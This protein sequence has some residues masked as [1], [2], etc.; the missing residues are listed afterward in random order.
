MFYPFFYLPYATQR[1]AMDIKNNAVVGIHYTLKNSN[2][3]VLDSSEDRDPLYFLHG[4]GNIIPGL[5]S[6]LTGKSAG[7]AMEVTVEPE[8]GYGLRRDDLIQKSPR[9]AFE[10][11]DSLEVGMQF[12]A[13]TETGPMLISVAEING[14]EITVDANHE[15]AGEQLHFSVNIDSVREATEQ[16]VG[17]GHVH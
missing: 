3:D 15:L 1:Y 7:E 17:H 14:D 5:E 12:Q 11:V 16:E 13:Q 2:G 4:H 9:S 10:G 6:A 8:Q